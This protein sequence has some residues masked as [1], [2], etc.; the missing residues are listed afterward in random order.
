MTKNQTMYWNLL[1]LATKRVYSNRQQ[2]VFYFDLGYFL[3]CGKTQ[4]SG[5]KAQVSGRKTLGNLTI[6]VK[7]FGQQQGLKK[8]GLENKS[9]T[10]A[11]DEDENLP[12][13]VAQECFLYKHE[14]CIK[15]RKTTMAI[16]G[17]FTWIN[18]RWHSAMF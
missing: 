17:A 8:K 13:S 1:P 6:S 15:S 10:V 14:E 16:S 11:E 5:K 7:P 18:N 12:N 3:V 9:I 2:V 4:I